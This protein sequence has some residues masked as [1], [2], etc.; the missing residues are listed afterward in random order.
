MP[1]LILTV[2][3]G[4]SSCSQALMFGLLPGW[5]SATTRMLRKTLTGSSSALSLAMLVL[6]LCAMRILRA[7][8]ASFRIWDGHLFH[9]SQTSPLLSRHPKSSAAC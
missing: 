9:S 2:S 7:A 4:G 1:P 6:A 8:K 3:S 5:R